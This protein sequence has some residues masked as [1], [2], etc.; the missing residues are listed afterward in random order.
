MFFAHS[1][2][3]VCVAHFLRA[4]LLPADVVK[5]F[6]ATLAQLRPGI[7][8]YV[9]VRISRMWDTIIP[10]STEPKN[11]CLL[12][13]DEKENAIQAVISREA[14]PDL[15]KKFVVGRVYKIM[16][17]QTLV[18]KTGYNAIPSEF[19]V[20][21]NGG[22]EFLEISENVERFPRYHFRFASMEQ[23]RCRH[24]RDPVL[25]DVIGMLVS[26]GQAGSVPLQSGGSADKMDIYIRLA[27]E[28]VLRITLWGSHIDSVNDPSILLTA[29]EAGNFALAGTVVKEFSNRKLLWTC[30]VSK[31]FVDLEI[32]KSAAIRERFAAD[33]T[34]VEILASDEADN[35]QAAMEAEDV[36]INDLYYEDPSTMKGKRYRVQ[37]KVKAI[38]TTNGWY[39]ETCPDCGVKL[40]PVNGRFAC[41]DHGGVTPRFV[42]QLILLIEDDSASIEVAVFG[43]LAQ[44]FI[45]VGVAA[46]VA[47]SNS[48]VM[49]AK[50]PP[51]AKNVIGKEFL[52]TVGLSDQTIKRGYLKYKVYK[53][54]P[55]VL[56][57]DDIPVQAN[58]NKGKQIIGQA[59][60]AID[61][62][63]T[64]GSLPILD[65]FVSVDR[66]MVVEVADD[67]DSVIIDDAAA[68]AD[69][70]GGVGLL[71][72]L[73]YSGSAAHQCESNLDT[74][75]ATPVLID[76]SRR[77]VDRASG[78]ELTVGGDA[79]ELDGALPADKKRGRRGRDIQ[80]TALP[81]KKQGASVG[82]KKG[83]TSPDSSFTPTDLFCEESPIKLSHERPGMYTYSLSC[84]QWKSPSSLGILCM[85][86]YS[87]FHATPVLQSSWSSHVGFLPSISL[88]LP[89]SR[90]M[91]GPRVS[92]CI[93]ND[94]VIKT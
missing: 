31:I 42:M 46:A 8:A 1:C 5:L 59:G 87:G 9:I 6:H 80:Q 74:H 60:P 89:W 75:C 39:Y 67:K 76:I 55:T 72:A 77:V 71:N 35:Y 22:T 13:L 51:T 27:S 70:I 19:I 17:F 90:C 18:C 54:S 26:A 11:H 14:M 63:N 15:E 57:G 52:F 25:T 94:S 69:G 34:A 56:I 16:R 37:A 28:D 61:G 84:I 21:F 82:K 91:D 88:L 49:K 29:A 10:G 23:I 81:P 79:C 83:M 48:G 62:M 64:L 41:F 47:G 33:K 36:F 2:R 66:N 78:G 68:A 4:V 44:S 30:S 20:H 38:N 24:E 85:H 3:P 58:V 92:A 45:G 50:L 53:Y 93:R 86:I 7:R 65:G 73:A 12:L 40:N 32:L 43:Q